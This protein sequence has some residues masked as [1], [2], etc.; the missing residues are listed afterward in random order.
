MVSYAI[1][2]IKFVKKLMWHAY[3]KLFFLKNLLQS[4]I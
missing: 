3:Y 4:D 2:A 1:A